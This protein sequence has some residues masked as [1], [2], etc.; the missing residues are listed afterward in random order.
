MPSDAISRPAS[1]EILSLLLFLNTIL[2]D[3]IISKAVSTK[4]PS[5]SNRINLII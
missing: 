4:V 2:A 5:K 1:Y 3:S